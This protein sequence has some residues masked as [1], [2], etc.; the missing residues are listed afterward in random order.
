MK[1][2]YVTVIQSII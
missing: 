2:V 1:G